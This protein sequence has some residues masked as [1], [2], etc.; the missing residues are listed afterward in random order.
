MEK[1]DGH[2]ANKTDLIKLDFFIGP[3]NLDWGF[4]YSQR[5]TIFKG[6]LMEE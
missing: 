3:D 5:F 1:V 4:M 6:G 2:D